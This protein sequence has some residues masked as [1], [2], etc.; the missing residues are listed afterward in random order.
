MAT[1][2]KSLV[3]DKE[4]AVGSGRVG[5]WLLASSSKS[6][7]GL[8]KEG[9]ARGRQREH[10]DKNRTDKNSINFCDSTFPRRKKSGIL[11]LYFG[12]AYL[13]QVF[14]YDLCR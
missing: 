10:G 7:S 9:Q 3:A 1:R 2:M 5:E 4:L 6:G 12:H 14:V 8:R 11:V 13:A